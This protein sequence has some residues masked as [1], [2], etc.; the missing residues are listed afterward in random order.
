MDLGVQG[1]GGPGSRVQG[2]HTFEFD[3]HQISR[4]VMDCIGTK[5]WNSAIGMC[6]GGD[7]NTL[8]ILCLSADT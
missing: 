6:K 7:P 1:P 5:V 8:H 2:I 3:M 4:H